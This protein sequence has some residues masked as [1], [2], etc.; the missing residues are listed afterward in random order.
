MREVPAV[1]ELD[2]G[3]LV[4]GLEDVTS[5][6]IH[7]G[8]RDVTQLPPAERDIAMV[9]QSYA[10]YPHMTVS[11]NITFGLRTAKNDKTDTERRLAR[12]AFSVSAC[13]HAAL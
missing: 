10:L 7:I 8:G 12:A 6:S 2:G 3:E 5:G 4:A 9:F 11:D 13:E 1:A